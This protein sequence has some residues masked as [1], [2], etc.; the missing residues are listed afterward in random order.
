MICKFFALAA[1]SGVMV[2]SAASAAAQPV[3][4]GNANSN[5]CYP[6][7]CFAAEGGETYQ[8]VYDAGAFSGSFTIE[9]FTLF[10]GLDFGTGP[11][12]D[13]SWTVS[14]YTTDK[15]PSAL[16]SSL[17][18]NRGTLLANFGVFGVSGLMPAEL[19][20]D[21]ADFVYD[22]SH[23]NLLLQV[24]LSQASAIFGAHQFFQADDTGVLTSRALAY[25]DGD[26]RVDGQAL[27]TRF[28]GVASVPE[29]T[30]WA[31][32]IVGMAAVGGALRRRASALTA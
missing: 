19:T 13:A 10:K 26:S 11:M 17:G 16:S 20:I 3:T 12:D 21:G 31:L 18:D 29:P 25:A 28:N 15:A 5:N 9:S 22:P 2:L 27:V 14:F 30:T 32:L 4:I 7:A 1:A 24:E 8:Q 23:G 6:F